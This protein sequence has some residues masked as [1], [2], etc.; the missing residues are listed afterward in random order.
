MLLWHFAQAIELSQR[1][2]LARVALLL[3]L[4]PRFGV[5]WGR[6]AAWFG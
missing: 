1:V 3:L 5:R 2:D 6:L 4:Y